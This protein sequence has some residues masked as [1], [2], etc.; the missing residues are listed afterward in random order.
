MADAG[1]V[2]LFV[3]FSSACGAWLLMFWERFVTACQHRV[4]G[5]WHICPG[6]GWANAAHT[7]CSGA[8][9][10]RILVSVQHCSRFI[11]TLPSLVSDA[12]SHRH[13]AV[14]Y[15][16]RAVEFGS[17]DLWSSTCWLFRLFHSAV[18]TVEWY[19]P[20]FL[21]TPTP[22]CVACRRLSCWLVPNPYVVT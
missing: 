5:C 17:L 13:A 16:Q 1:K 11:A 20:H 7:P 22:R 14:T 21:P 19:Q 4:F 12:A 10:I 2:G 6:V 3:T 8:W 15:I 18:L 9:V